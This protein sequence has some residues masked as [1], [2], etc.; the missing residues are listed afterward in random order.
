MKK[1]S[2]ADGPFTVTVPLGTYV[3]SSDPSVAD[4][5]VFLSLLTI[6]PKRVGSTAITAAFG[7]DS[8][9][10]MLNVVE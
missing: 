7:I 3:T 6:T 2:L 10:G 8:A 1:V 5:D 4:V 9:A